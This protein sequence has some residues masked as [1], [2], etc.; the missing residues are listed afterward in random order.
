MKD[1]IAFKENRPAKRGLSPV[2]A[3]IEIP[4]I[5]SG[6]R[7]KRSYNSRP[8][9]HTRPLGGVTAPQGN[10]ISLRM[11][12][13][14][15]GAERERKA[16]LEF[17]KKLKCRFFSSGG[18]ETQFSLGNSYLLLPNFT[19]RWVF[20]PPAKFHPKSVGVYS[21]SFSDLGATS[22]RRATLIRSCGLGFNSLLMRI[23]GD[24]D[25]SFGDF[26]IIRE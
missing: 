11:D 13:C 4:T 18:E 5:V 19:P 10:S 7:G 9:T 15:A 14:R 6:E 20:T 2:V 17:P 25:R 8:H 1:F 22:I 26:F 16:V 24:N 21:C 23:I 3:C 12:T